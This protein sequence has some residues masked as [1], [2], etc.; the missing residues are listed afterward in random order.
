MASFVNPASGESTT[1]TGVH[2]FKW[3]VV[4]DDDLSKNLKEIQ[5]WITTTTMNGTVWYAWADLVVEWLEF[6]VTGDAVAPRLALAEVIG[7][8]A[9]VRGLLTILD[10]MP[11]EALTRQR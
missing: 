9:V 11:K 10:P 8:A 4:S 5:P 7:P 6:G 1:D 3:V 2:L